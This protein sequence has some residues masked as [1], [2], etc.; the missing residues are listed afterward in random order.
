MALEARWHRRFGC[1]GQVRDGGKGE[2]INNRTKQVSVCMCVGGNRES[3]ECRGSK[4]VLVVCFC[5]SGGTVRMP[6]P[7]SSTSLLHYDITLCRP[8]QPRLV[9]SDERVSQ[10]VPSSHV[11]RGD[12]AASA[13]GW[14]G[15]LHS[16]IRR[17]KGGGEGMSVC[18]CL[19]VCAL[20][21]CVCL[22]SA[23][24][25]PQTLEKTWQSGK[26][27]CRSPQGT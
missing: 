16:L 23:L 11:I 2:E 12:V 27:F 26:A 8:S 20:C 1:F 25:W 22:C 5:A 9:G 14:A 17:L 4:E 18:M 7:P 13:A 24:T 21:V 15:A 3:M 10:L 6:P 19:C